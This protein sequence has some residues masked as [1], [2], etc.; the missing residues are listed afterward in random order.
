[1]L[2]AKWLTVA[3][4]LVYHRGTVQPGMHALV[5]ATAMLGGVFRTSIS[6]VNLHSST[7]H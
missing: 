3:T 5:G 4:F 2:S 6:L 1:V 7:F